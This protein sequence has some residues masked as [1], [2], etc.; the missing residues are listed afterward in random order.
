MSY[1]KGETQG[2]RIGV[3]GDGGWGTTIALHLH[4]R[5]YP[6]TLWGA[7]PDYVAFVQQKRENVKFLPGVP[8]PSGLTM[9]AD[10]A[11]AVQGAQLVVLAVPSQFMRGVCKKLKDLEGVETR[12]WVSVAKGIEQQ[13]LCRMSEAIRQE[14]PA[15]RFCVLSGPSHAEEVARFIPTTAVIA[16]EDVAAAQAA[17]HAFSSELFRIYTSSDVIGAEMGGALKNVMAIAVGI[18]DGMGYGDNTK[19]A[20]M[21]RGLDEITRLGIA[22]GAKA[23]TFAGLSGM[24]DLITTCVSRHSRNRNFGEMV[25][26]GMSAEDALKQTEMVVEGVQTTKSA[27]ALAK[28]LGV[29]VPIIEEVY[30]VLYER[31]SPEKAVHDLLKR[32]PK[33]E[34]ER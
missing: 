31:K 23:E 15:K 5:G 33:S 26:K 6:V 19:A 9:T 11:A 25:G 16:S 24:G 34:I 27:H 29:E 12:I 20:L 1:D 14:M 22:L 2:W 32:E 28:K 30:A 21:T 4:R 8:I 13:T 3:L 10:L 17:Q 18:S 7:F